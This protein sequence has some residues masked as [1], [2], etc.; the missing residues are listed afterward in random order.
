VGGNVYNAVIHFAVP[1]LFV[2]SGY[3]L[4]DKQE[5]DRIFFSKRFSKVVILMVAWSMI[6]MIFANKYDVLSIFTEDFVRK[7]FANKIYYHLYFLYNIIGLYP[8]HLCYAGFWHTQACTMSITSW[9]YGSYS[10]LSTG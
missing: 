8:S 3:L 1:I 10:R 2:L 7:F 4:L 6:Y 9:Y 5:D